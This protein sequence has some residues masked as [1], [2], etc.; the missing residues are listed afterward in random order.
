MV[1]ARHPT[2]AVTMPVH[3]GARYIDQALASIVTQTVAVDEVIVVDDGSTDDSASRA[4][5]WTHLLPVRVISNQHQMRSWRSRD[6]AIREASAELILQLDADDVL[7]PH[8]VAVMVD[9][10]LAHPGLVSPRRLSLHEV[11]ARGMLSS[12]CERAP[13]RQEQLAQLILLNY[14]GIGSLFKR[15]DYLAVGGF[16]D[17]RVAGDWDLWL[18]MAAAG[19]PISKPEE[20]TYLY[21]THASNISSNVNRR[22]TDPEILEKYLETCSDAALRQLTRLSIMQRKGVRYLDEHATRKT[23]SEF[24]DP[25]IGIIRLGKPKAGS[26]TPMSVLAERDGAVVLTG[27]FDKHGHLEINGLGPAM[28]AISYWPD[29]KRHFGSP[30]PDGMLWN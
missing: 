25:D 9:T 6:A 17:C 2:I 3:N 11:E 18:R 8:H 14:V 19:M 27:R 16:H 29:F 12:F 21:R 26:G 7:L 15:D 20:S 22:D 30:K 1:N 10:Y 5:Q 4:R 13:A 23:Q 24:W 28:T